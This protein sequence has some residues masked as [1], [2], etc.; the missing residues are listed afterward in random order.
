M[1]HLLPSVGRSTQGI[2][3][4]VVEV[5]SGLLFVGGV[6]FLPGALHHG[7]F[8]QSLLEEVVAGGLQRL[9][10]DAPPQRSQAIGLAELPQRRV[11][12]LGAVSTHL[13]R[14]GQV[15]IAAEDGESGALTGVVEGNPCHAAHLVGEPVAQ[16][17]DRAVGAPGHTDGAC[18]LH[19]R[20]AHGIIHGKLLVGNPRV[21]NGRDDA[22][23]FVLDQIAIFILAFRVGNLVPRTQVEV[24]ALIVTSQQAGNVLNAHLLVGLDAHGQV[25]DVVGQAQ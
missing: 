14:R 15:G 21:G 11:V 17:D 23:G 10:E 3:C 18:P 13:H 7:E 20:V 9:A 6:E 1:G 16:L 12:V 24:S 8:A 5:Q 4:V 19:R 2:A 22:V 25:L